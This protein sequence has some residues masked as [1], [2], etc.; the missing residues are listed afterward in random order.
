MNDE[1]LFDV[2]SRPAGGI[3]TVPAFCSDEKTHIFGLTESASVPNGEPACGKDVIVVRPGTDEDF[4][5]ES[6]YIAA[7]SWAQGGTLK[8]QSKDRS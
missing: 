8:V 7:V 1:A 6:C 4:I 3:R 5:C 2:I